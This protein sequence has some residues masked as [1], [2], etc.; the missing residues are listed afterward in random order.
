M[1]TKQGS[2]MPMFRNGKYNSD[3]NLRCVN[4]LFI[5]IANA[6]ANSLVCNCILPLLFFMNLSIFQD[7]MVVNIDGRDNSHGLLVSIVNSLSIQNPGEDFM[8]S[9]IGFIS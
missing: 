5:L 3:F 4:G 2:T 8:C 1:I 6:L 7:D 9:E